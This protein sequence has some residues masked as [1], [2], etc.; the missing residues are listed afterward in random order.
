MLLGY[1]LSH[2]NR[3]LQEKVTSLLVS[4][5]K[6]FQRRV[7]V[8]ELELEELLLQQLSMLSVQVEPLFGFFLY[9]LIS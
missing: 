5:S 7:A 1:L 8:Q 9:N 2:L 3:V 6:F 4:R